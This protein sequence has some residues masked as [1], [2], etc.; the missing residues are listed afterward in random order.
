MGVFRVRF[1][2]LWTK[3]LL[4]LPGITQNNLALEN[5]QGKAPQ[6]RK[7]PQRDAKL[8]RDA[9]GTQQKKE[10]KQRPGGRRSEKDAKGTQ[11]KKEQRDTKAAGCGEFPCT[12]CRDGN[13]PLGPDLNIP[14]LGIWVYRPTAK[15]NHN[16]LIAQRNQ[17][18]CKYHMVYDLLFKSIEW[19]LPNMCFSNGRAI[20]PNFVKS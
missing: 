11:Q 9:K 16:L 1:V 8:K 14:S 17:S 20:L 10:Q 3:K 7:V 4:T 5:Q 2:R 6:N 18:Q 12:A 15:N 13:P 19:P